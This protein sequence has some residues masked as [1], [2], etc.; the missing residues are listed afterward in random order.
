MYINAEEVKGIFRNETLDETVINMG[1]GLNYPVL[2]TIAEV[3][4]KLEGR[5]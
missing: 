2:E 1:N 4:E 3:L 5:K